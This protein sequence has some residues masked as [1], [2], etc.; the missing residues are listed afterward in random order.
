MLEHCEEPT[1]TALLQ[2][3]HQCAA[4]LIND[5]YGNY[6]TQHVIEHGRD[7]DRGKIVS[8]ITQNL[9]NFSK[10][11]FA[12]N[13]VEKSIQ[14]GSKDERQDIVRTLTAVNDRGDSPVQILI[15]DQYGN[16]VVRK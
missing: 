8:L 3:L 14:F 9:V 13:V 6:V 2:E 10:H 16:Y 11:K 5:Q 12:S 7:E 4:S 15:R 1:R